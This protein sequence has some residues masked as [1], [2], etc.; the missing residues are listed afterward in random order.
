MLRSSAHW[1]ASGNRP[2]SRRGRYRAG[3]DDDEPCDLNGRVCL[4]PHRPPTSVT[5][6]SA[7]KSARRLIARKM[8]GPA[9]MDAAGGSGAFR[10]TVRTD[11]TS[12]IGL[13]EMPIG[14]RERRIDHNLAH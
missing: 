3:D 5:S 12:G 7:S 2:D 8:S 14:D 13:A 10:R 1:P 6:V 9:A 4:L 11:F